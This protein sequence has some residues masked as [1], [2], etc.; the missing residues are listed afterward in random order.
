MP[1]IA[2][3]QAPAVSFADDEFVQITHSSEEAKAALSKNAKLNLSMRFAMN[4]LQLNSRENQEIPCELILEAVDESGISN[5]NASRGR[6]GVDIVCAIDI[7]GSM[8]GS[9]L[10][11][12]KRTLEFMIDKL[13]DNDRVSLV[14]FN[15]QSK[16]L[17]PLTAMTPQGK[18]RLKAIAGQI[19]AFAGTEI[20]EGLLTSLNILAQ[21]RITNSVSS[22][23]LLSDGNDNNTHSA[24]GRTKSALIEVGSMISSGY[25]IHTFGYGAD[26]DPNLLNSMAEEKNGGFYFV[27]RDEL[28]GEAFSSCLGELI[29]VVA[30][31][32]QIS[33]QT[34]QTDIRFALTKVY[35]ESGDQSF[36][37]PPILSG[38]K[39]E[40]IFLLNFFPTIDAVP[41]GHQIQPV[42]AT[43]Q[44]RLT[45]SGHVI[46]EES[47]L[48]VPIIN[49]SEIVN[50]I[51]LDEDVMVN[52]YRVKTADI[53]KEAGEYGER[54]NMQAARECLLR[55][56]NELKACVVSGHEVI[57]VLISD[58]E[59]AVNRFVSVDAW[60]H[61]GKAE[62]KSKARNH[63]AKRAPDVA[64]YQ[65]CVQKA[66]N[67]ESKN[68]Y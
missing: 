2:A 15:N 29:S 52:F 54:N 21:R 50:E 44:Y 49:E 46:R 32:V 12:V 40:A 3:P 43:V 56:A 10:D 25:S 24:M 7:S 1:F 60:E 68:Y 45:R 28:I 35:S 31:N 62:M 26:H 53:L 33:L 30:D 13:S 57:Q 14:T 59:K 47:F 38:D 65:N 18:G 9:K 55:G 36:R 4:Y 6:P 39:K 5:P 48:Q 27:E 11:L 58:L 22:I 8:R 16:R 34:L 64:S 23:I 51:E 61:G 37:F 17:C 42:K 67:L 19:Q 66:F 20:V 41:N 63:W